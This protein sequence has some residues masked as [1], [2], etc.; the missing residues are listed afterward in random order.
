MA[1]GNSKSSFLVKAAWAL[2]ASIA[3]IVAF[4]GTGPAYHASVE[5][6]R[7][8][9]IEQYGYVMADIVTVLWWGGVAVLLFLTALLTIVL[10]FLL[11]LFALRR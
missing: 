1:A 4:A 11:S 7:A 8:F 2:A 5:A 3:V 10:A 9:T 6:V